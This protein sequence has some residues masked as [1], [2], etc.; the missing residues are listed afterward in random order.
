M[1]FQ[2]ASSLPEWTLSFRN[3]LE[4]YT[5]VSQYQKQVNALNMRISMLQARHNSLLPVGRLPPE[6]LGEIFVALVKDYV[7]CHYLDFDK[8]DH[9]DRA[10]NKKI[11]HWL[12]I[13]RVCRYWTDVAMHTPRVWS[14]I[15]LGHISVQTFLS[16]LQR[17][18]QSPLT[19]M[20]PPWR[21]VMSRP[22]P[23]IEGI[24]QNMHRMRNLI[25]EVT[26][27]F[28]E[29]GITHGLNAPKLE[30]LSVYAAQPNDGSAIEAISSAHWPS[31]KTL[32]S[33]ML[34]QSFLAAAVRSSLTSLTVKRILDAHP[35]ETWADLLKGLPNL[36]N[37]HVEDAIRELDLDEHSPLSVAETVTLRKLKSA[38]FRDSGSGCASAHL[39][40]HLIFVEDTSLELDGSRA[41][42]MP[43][44]YADVVFIFSA[45]AAK[46]RADINTTSGK[47]RVVR[48]LEVTFK[49]WANSDTYHINI[50]TH[51][52][53][54]PPTNIFGEQQSTVDP[55]AVS[56]AL[57]CSE[58]LRA[59][60]TVYPLSKVHSLRIISE[61]IDNDIEA[62]RLLAVHPN[63]R[64]VSFGNQDLAGA[65]F[66]RLQDSAFF[67]NLES[68]TLYQLRW[69]KL[70]TYG[71]K[72]VERRGSL[73][74][75]LMAALEAR[76]RD[77]RGIKKLYIPEPVN[78]R[79]YDGYK[80][81]LLRLGELVEYCDVDI[82]GA[83]Y[84]DS[85]CLSCDED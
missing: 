68:L 63:I 58:T 32:E 23:W 17:S 85:S 69:N 73:I 78:L 31:L 50:F 45:L 71:Q 18:G 4:I 8:Y 84:T 77:G 33:V 29:C 67:P 6:I 64:E 38:S 43:V 19:V 53:L 5:A 30:L 3:E 76:N 41:F 49:G 66:Q 60:C 74:P 22:E 75:P 14:Y 83:P 51:G 80:E 36:E 59:F 70:H 65:F 81:D 54:P 82:D 20:Q 21:S 13:I 48:A 27:E 26:P 40:N 34:S 62:L 2:M 24:V 9:Y 47:T 72:I 39:L 10:F 16:F 61:T 15:H 46:A 12:A 37:L 57:R 44:T 42:R 1:Y 79:E 56:V 55:P 52:E 25:S 11:Y 7:Q 28:F 35:A